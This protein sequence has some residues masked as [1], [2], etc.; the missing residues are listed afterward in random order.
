M[1]RIFYVQADSEISW[2]VDK[3]IEV[4]ANYVGVAQD[5]IDGVRTR[6]KRHVSEKG[7][8]GSLVVFWT[9]V[10]NKMMAENILLGLKRDGTIML[11]D[12]TQSY[13]NAPERAGAVYVYKRFLPY[14]SNDYVIQTCGLDGDIRSYYKKSSVFSNIYYEN[15]NSDLPW[16][17]KHPDTYSESSESSDESSSESDDDGDA[18]NPYYDSEEEDLIRAL[19]EL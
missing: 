16:D 13:S 3:A 8:N 18:R 2:L 4:D 19:R 11:E 1:V 17:S 7:I 6:A 15:T 14:R 10:S 9:N 12:N 5:G